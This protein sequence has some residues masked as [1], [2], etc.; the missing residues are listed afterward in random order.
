[1]EVVRTSSGNFHGLFCHGDRALLH[2]LD[3]LVLDE[4]SSLTYISDV[5]LVCALGENRD[6]E[7]VGAVVQRKELR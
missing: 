5:V 7:K 1:M 3:L 2:R 6:R 4:Q